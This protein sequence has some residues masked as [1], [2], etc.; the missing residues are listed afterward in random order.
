MFIFI[1][2]CS[3][4][5]EKA[6]FHCFLWKINM[7]CSKTALTKLV[8]LFCLHFHI[9]SAVALVLV[10]LT[11]ITINPFPLVF[12]QSNVCTL[13]LFYSFLIKW[14]LKSSLNSFQPHTHFI[15]LWS[16]FC[17]IKL[18]LCI[19]LHDFL[20]SWSNFFNVCSPE[21]LILICAWNIANS[22]TQL[23]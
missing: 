18:N 6:C 11:G 14:K 7:M 17:M 3:E 15:A 1:C 10:M 9:L 22:R 16:P 20:A 21:T 12:M 23:I 8:L 19:W 5:P 13:W 2:S 4:S